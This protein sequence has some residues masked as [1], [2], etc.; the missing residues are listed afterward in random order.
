MGSLQQGVNDLYSWCMKNGEWGQQLLFEF[1][2]G[3]NSQQFFDEETGMFKGPM[4]FSKGSSKKIK[5]TC[6]KCGK[7]WESDIHNRTAHKTGCK[8]CSKDTVGNKISQAKTKRDSNDLYTWCT[9]NG[10]WGQQILNEWQGID[11]N[12]NEIDIHKIAK[13]SNKKVLWKC[14]KGHVWDAP[15]SSRT[16]MMSR[17]KYCYSNHVVREDNNLYNWCLTNGEF[18]ERIINEWTGIDEDN[19]KYNIHDIT[20]GSRKRF[21]WKCKNCGDTWITSVVDRI[22]YKTHCP[23]CNVKGTSYPEQFL[24]RALK[25]IYPKT[26]SRGKVQNIEYDITIPELKLCIEYSGYNWHKNKRDKD[27]FKEEFCKKHNVNFIQIYAHNGI[28]EEDD[29]FEDNLIIYKEANNRDKHTVQLTYILEFILRRFNR[30]IKEIDIKKAS[31]EA[32]DFMYNR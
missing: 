2:D 28:I 7:S 32:Y 11:V 26:I 12:G 23:K 6:I 5:W 14:N 4:D 17:C 24:Y 3:N 8:Y 15:I 31:E 16:Y 27:A 13:A 29:K 30:S 9:Q 18:G 1:G 25:Q 22:S 10:E 20:K 21:I 19:N